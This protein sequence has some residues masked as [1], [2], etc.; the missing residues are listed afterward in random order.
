M[1]ITSPNLQCPPTPSVNQ[2]R[3][4]HVYKLLNSPRIRLT[5][6]QLTNVPRFLHLIP[7]ENIGLVECEKRWYEEISS[8]KKFY[9]KKSN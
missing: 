9:I 2:F 5:H 4:S 3:L 7:K 6:L 1:Q 8:G